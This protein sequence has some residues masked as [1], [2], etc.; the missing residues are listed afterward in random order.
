MRVHPVKL[1]WL[2]S[3]G[4][5][6]CGRAQ[7]GGG[8]SIQFSASGEALA[9]GG[10]NFPATT[11]G[12]P[13]FV[14]GWEIKFSKFIAVFDKITLSETP[15]RSPSDQSQLG[16]P[17]AEVDGPWAI[18]L[19][20]G[21]SL[22]GKGG[23]EEQ[24][25]PLTTID[26]QNLNGGAA[27][28]PSLRYAFGF[29][30]VPASNA[31]FR[32]GIAAD[33]PDWQEM[34]QK[35]WNVLYVGTATWH[36]DAQGV[37]CTSTDPNYDFSTLPRTV[38]FRL[39][40]ASPTSYVNCQN[41]DNDPANP[42]GDEEH[43]RGIQVKA[44]QAT[45]AQVTFHS[46]HPF[47]ESVAHDSPAHF[48]QLAALASD[49]GHGTFR[50]SFEAATQANY[51]AFKDSG[52][53]PLPWR[54]CV[55]DYTPPNARSQMGFDSGSVPFNPQGN[56]SLVLRNYADY[57]YYNQSTQGHLNSDGLCF[58]NRHFPSPP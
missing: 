11:S 53:H 42:L 29:D 16:N 1:F 6:A 32:I 5:A 34:V 51:T 47:W 19:H 21:G 46:D 9:L 48:D 38:A 41:P 57:M 12:D 27:F 39:G 45:I 26:N 49:D 22:A 24:A 7:N 43:Q 30:S 2:M 35:G 15:D 13:A 8:G 4:L 40:F 17:V 31:A 37:S 3:L 20:Q 28:D 10:Y 52:G 55:A 58:V 14:D 23:G 33:D 36:G 18:D 56:A 25:A 50:V 44:N 54:S